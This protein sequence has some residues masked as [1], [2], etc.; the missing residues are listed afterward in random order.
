[1]SRLVL[2]FNGA[3]AACTQY[4]TVGAQPAARLKVRVRYS[5]ESTFNEEILTLNLEVFGWLS[6][7]LVHTSTLL[8]WIDASRENHSPTINTVPRNVLQQD[9]A[10]S[11]LGHQRTVYRPKQCTTSAPCW[12]TIAPT[13]Y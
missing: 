10:N 3:L 2:P 12:S 13:L 1:M 9:R 7:L 5:I 11:W 8:G 4:P 6:I